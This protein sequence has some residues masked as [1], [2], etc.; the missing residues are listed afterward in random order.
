[1]ARYQPGRDEAAQPRAHIEAGEHEGDKQR[2]VALWQVFGQ[3]RGGI[4]QRSPQRHTGQQAQGGQLIGVAGKGAGQAQDAETGDGKE[5]DFL[6]AQAV[7]VRPGSQG[8]DGQ[9]DHTGAHNR[10]ESGA[11]Q[12]PFLDQ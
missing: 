2:A 11:R 10:A 3:Q 1:M 12:A 4:G 6:A 5:H 9:P 8:A 7:S